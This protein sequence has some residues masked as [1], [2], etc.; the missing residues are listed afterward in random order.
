MTTY[1]VTG[2]TG[3]LGRLAVERL[4][5]TVPAGDVVAIVR[6]PE[7]AADLAAKGVAV[8]VADYGDLPAVVAA[9]EGV[10]RL[11][12]VSGSEVGKRIAQHGN[13]IDAARGAGVGRIVY[14]SAPAATTSALILAPEHKATEEY[15][16]DSGIPHTIVRNNW[17][18]DNY[19]RVVGA[20]RETGEIVAAVGDGRVASATRADYAAGAVA[21]L[22]DDSTEGKVFEF[23]GDTAWDFDELASVV[24]ELIGRPVV[25]VRVSPD[26]LVE[27]LTAA[28]VEAG[29]AGFAAALDANIAAGLL[30]NATHDLSTLL[31][32]PTT[33][34]REGLAAALPR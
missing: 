15:L 32:R 27:R 21:A 10:D 2:A 25:Y 8:R 14:T 29:G 3:H 20:A 5:E 1:A 33:P 18:T 26:E 19:V 30:G 23:S 9:L 16:A 12:L 11:L 28:G 17:Y 31:G 7:R 34:L 4:L 22:L 6:D 24:G 13:V